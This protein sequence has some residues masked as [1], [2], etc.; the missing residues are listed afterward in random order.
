MSRIRLKRKKIVRI[1]KSRIKTSAMLLISFIVFCAYATLM[2][3]QSNAILRLDAQ[4]NTLTAAYDTAVKNNDDLNGQILKARDLG[5]VDYYASQ[6]LGMKK[7][8]NSDIT[9]V[10]VSGEPAAAAAS[11]PSFMA[12]LSN[13]LN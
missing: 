2:V 8:S 10:A 9:Y 1:K 6:V 4:I 11:Q 13:L 3:W 12:W 5:A 7:S